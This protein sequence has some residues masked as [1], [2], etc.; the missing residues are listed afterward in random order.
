M[1]KKLVYLLFLLPLLTVSQ[2]TDVI[3]SNRP[4]QSV[5]AYAVGKNVLQTEF[6]I[7]YEKQEHRDLLT[8][9]NRLGGE[10]VVR[11]GLLF[12]ELE[13]SWEGTYLSEKKSYASLE[14]EITNVNF[15]KHRAG[16]K[17]L[18]YDPFKDPEKNKPNLLSWRANNVFQLKNLIPAVSLYGGANFNLGDNPFYP[19][20]P[21]ISYRGMLATQ[22]RLSPKFVLITNI[23]YDRIGT[24]FPEMSYIVSI[25]RGL[26]N[27]KWSVFIEN[28]GIKSDRY[29][30][31]L[32]RT[33]IAHLFNDRLQADINFGASFKHTPSQFYATMGA[34][35]R[36]DFH[37]DK[38]VP[39]QDQK[40]GENGSPI[41]KN[42][43]KKKKIK[44]KN[45]KKG[46]KKKPSDN[47]VIDF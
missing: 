41:K 2:Y 3:N 26:K 13:I 12:E 31:I 33:G 9:A 20:D 22:S 46:K 42:S 10:L 16:L 5:S 30:D 27:P 37:K 25:T 47:G 36:F 39:I 21:T 23:I 28:Q 29:A 40:A 17:Y 24:D 44:K 1:K 7:V 18:I 6:G 8:T 43:M 34:S 35:Y 14:E 4:G 45:R 19:E 32:L 38:L 15:T 11:Y